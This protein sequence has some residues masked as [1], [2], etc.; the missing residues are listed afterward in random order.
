MADSPLEREVPTLLNGS[1]VPPILYGTA[2]RDGKP[3]PD[4]VAALEAGYRAIDSANS[5]L[6]H[7]EDE[8]GQAVSTFVA[9]NTDSVSR[10][11]IF[12][13]S[14][15]APPTEQAEPWPYDMADDTTSR[16][17]KSVLRSAAD[18]RLETI[19][20]YFLH[21][22]LGSLS[23]TLEA[24]R[25]LERIVDRGG[26]RYLGIA[27]VK[28]PR[29]RQLFDQ[30]RVKPAFVQNW[31]RRD[32]RYDRGVAAFCRDHGIVYQVFGVF[33]GENAEL[34][35]CDSVRRHARDQ[36]ITARQALLRMISAAAASRGL[37]L[38]VLDGTTDRKHME[39]NLRAVMGLP[40][41]SK[42]L[43]QSFSS[44]IGWLDSAAPDGVPPFPN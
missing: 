31:F 12:I 44:L 16:V 18:L 19:D 29:L 20:A 41:P 13:Q 27:N 40:E 32:T 11:A 24:W 23:G 5:R 4:V 42:E 15:Y 26:I 36:S 8:D 21:T 38:C 3:R 25:A 22:P 14:K 39:E 33:D 17:Y 35:R 37:R 10:D 1:P 43:V 9:N 34:L 7:R 28:A 30:A 6:F 2:V